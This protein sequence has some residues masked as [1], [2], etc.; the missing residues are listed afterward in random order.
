MKLTRFALPLAASLAAVALA[1]CSS[2]AAAPSAGTSGSPSASTSVDVVASTNVWGDITAKVGGDKVD[3]TSIIDDPDKDPHEYEA[4]AQNQLALSKAKVV[5]ENGGGYDD[6]VDTM[7]ASAKN[8]SAKVLN[9]VT[10]SGKKAA[11]GDEL[12]EHVWYD[13]PTIEGDRPDPDHVCGHRSGQCRHLRQQRQ[14]AQGFDRRLVKKEADLKKDPT[15][16]SPFRSLSRCR[17]TCSRRS[18]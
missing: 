15:T 13:F 11:A 6:F 9:A 18:V 16:G 5:I 1:S 4:S 12:N 14:A 2:P 17:C 3:V 10:I 8:D 7:L